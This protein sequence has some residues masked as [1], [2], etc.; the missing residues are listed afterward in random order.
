MGKIYFLELEE[1]LAIHHNQIETFGG[2][3]GLRDLNLLISA[4]SRPQ[5]T[6]GGNDLYP[7]MYLKAAALMHS[8]IM[9][10]PFVDGNK[11]I[12]VVS[13]ARFLFI[14]GFKIKVSNKELV[15]NVMKIES[16]KWDIE[17]LA[18]WLEENAKKIK[19]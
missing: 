3:H 9:N 10:H 4:I 2:S 13:V 18:E 5:T 19:S 7:T 14:N 11:R 6:F 16:K 1:I 17:K 8:L 12:A 15:D